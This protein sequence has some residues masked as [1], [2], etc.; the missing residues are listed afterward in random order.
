MAG[1]GSLEEKIKNTS[2]VV[3][4]IS[5]LG[6]YT[7]KQEN[8]L[9]K[10]HDILI[11][12]S[13]CFENSP[14]VIYEA[15]QNATPII[16]SKIGGIPEL[17]IEG[18]NGLLFKAGDIEN[19]VDRLNYIYENKNLIASMREKCIEMVREFD[20]KNYINKILNFKF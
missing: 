11:V 13:L 5:Y 1:R 17:V 10:N 16:A 4:N 18:E 15:M 9:F 6:S 12:P 19:L 7:K 20:I 2:L 3:N 14:M 8:E